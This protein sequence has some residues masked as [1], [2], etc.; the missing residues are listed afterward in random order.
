MS[1]YGGKNC[2]CVCA[3]I[4]Y[5]TVP[6]VLPR[7]GSA[8][9]RWEDRKK[10]EAVESEGNT[11]MLS[12]GGRL[13][14]GG[15]SRGDANLMAAAINNKHRSLIARESSFSLSFFIF[16]SLSP[17]VTHRLCLCLVF[18]ILLQPASQPAARASPFP[19]SIAYP[20][21][22]SASLPTVREVSY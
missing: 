11:G 14:G 9:G 19:G 12:G 13:G 15:N 22:P 7:D 17:S 1:A 5:I 4:Y 20:F 8:T 16:P 3:C 10:K 6:Y 21:H 2:L 18:F